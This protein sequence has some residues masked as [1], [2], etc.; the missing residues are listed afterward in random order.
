MRIIA[1]A[2]QKGGC[3]KT[4]TAINLAY[5]LSIRG[6][7][8]LLIDCDPQAH[9]TMGLKI[10]PSD[11]ERSLYD[12]LTPKD[13]HSAGIESII[14]PVNE[15]LHLA[16]SSII[17]SAVEQELSGIEGREDRLLQA[18]Q[19]ISNQYAY[20]IIDCPPSVGLLCF[21][22]LRASSEVIIP[23]DMSLFSLRGIA[24]LLE[25][26]MMLKEELGHSITARALIT[27]Y[28]RR[29]K[30]S[31]RVLEKVR[32]EFGGN[33]FNTI[34]R[35]NI[36]L[37][38]TVDYGLPVGLFDKRSN[39]HFDYEQLAEELEGLGN[40]TRQEGTAAEMTQNMLQKTERYIGAVTQ[41]EDPEEA[42]TD[43][44]EFLAQSFKSCYPEMIQAMEFG[45]AGGLSE[46]E[47]ELEEYQD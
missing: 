40:A 17:L 43:M 31:Q 23:I 27:M 10:K 33:A 18:L 38:E 9:A 25:L 4:T 37:R 42:Q 30:Y 2:N 39:G 11:L 45:A 24:K 16:P 12:V 7:K 47:S 44:E 36:R 41:Q 28:D 8:V 15:N 32:E 22:A 1:V 21:N 20:C 46:D 13:G 14:I 6:K 19:S 5:S 29:T 26:T 35:Y 3:G 34:I